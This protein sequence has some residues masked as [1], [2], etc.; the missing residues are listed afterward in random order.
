[1]NRKTFTIG[2]CLVM[3]IVLVTMF[4]IMVAEG[5]PPEVGGI[6]TTEKDNNPFRKVPRC[7]KLVLENRE[8]WTQ[9]RD[10]DSNFT[11]ETKYRWF[12]SCYP[13]KIK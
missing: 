13:V 9:Y 1:M 7:P 4:A 2:Y 5:L 8:G 11:S 12:N 10:M 6:Y 3:S